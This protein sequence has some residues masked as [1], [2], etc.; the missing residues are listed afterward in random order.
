[1]GSPRLASRREAAKTWPYSDTC[2]LGILRTL[3][4]A[5]QQGSTSASI[6][7]QRTLSCVSD[8]ILPSL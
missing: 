2:Q 8:S 5:L 4:R 7:F 6:S 3:I 1:M